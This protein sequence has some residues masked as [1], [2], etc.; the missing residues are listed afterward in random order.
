MLRILL[1]GVGRRRRRRVFDWILD[2][3]LALWFVYFCYIDDW[4]SIDFGKR[5]ALGNYICHFSLLARTAC[6]LSIQL[7]S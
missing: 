5:V 1:R 7:N 2:S 3:F 6:S 4:K